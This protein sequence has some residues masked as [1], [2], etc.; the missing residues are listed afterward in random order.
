MAGG[1]QPSPYRGMIRVPARAVMAG[2]PGYP[3]PVPV[4]RS[5]LAL[6]GGDPAAKPTVDP[7][8][9]AAALSDPSA[10]SAT[11]DP[12]PDIA[13]LTVAGDKAR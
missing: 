11:A 7:E 13:A 10:D 2:L 9:L 8:P 5:R 6:L 3:V 4:Q 12:V 1:R